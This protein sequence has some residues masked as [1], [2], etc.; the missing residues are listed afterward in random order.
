MTLTYEALTTSTALE[1]KYHRFVHGIIESV[2]IDINVER[3]EFRSA[4]TKHYNKDFL[5]TTPSPMTELLVTKRISDLENST[6]HL[7]E[8]FL[9]YLCFLWLK[10]ASK[11]STSMPEWRR[12]VNG[13]LTQRRDWRFRCPFDFQQRKTRMHR[14]VGKERESMEVDTCWNLISH[15]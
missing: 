15:K 12:N 3:G 5:P 7:T 1:Y 11:E 9:S 13:D 4:I 6:Q 8:L 10:I 2:K 14:C